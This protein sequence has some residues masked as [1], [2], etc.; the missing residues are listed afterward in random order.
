[1]S[2][3]CNPT[4]AAESLVTAASSHPQQ[5]SEHHRCSASPLELAT[6]PTWLTSFP[7]PAYHCCSNWRPIA[8]HDTCATVLNAHPPPHRCSSSR[9]LPMSTHQLASICSA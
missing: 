6:K 3:P 9:L 4:P 2:P 1:M 5:V 8:S 7:L